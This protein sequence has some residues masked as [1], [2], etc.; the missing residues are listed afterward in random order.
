ML[1]SLFFAIFSCVTPKGPPASPNPEATVPALTYPDSPRGEA[2]DT[3]YGMDVADPY[4]WL[5]DMN[6]DT[7]QRWVA[8][9]NALTARHM[10][11][12]GERAAI[13]ERLT[14]RWDYPKL[15]VP[16]ARGA[17]RLASYNSGQLPQSVLRLSDVESGETRVL[18]DHASED[19]PDQ[20]HVRPAS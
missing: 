6:S 18:L 12:I 5:E 17:M 9:Q 16:D 14:Q 10:A 1:V 19:A 15:G 8:A 7:T 3:F 13:L 4:R 20:T 11:G 2:K